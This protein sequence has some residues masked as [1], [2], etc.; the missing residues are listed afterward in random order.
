[1][2]KD[3]KTLDQKS[4]S[5]FFNERFPA[6]DAQKPVP[7]A[8]T[9]AVKAPASKVTV[10]P[11][12]TPAKVEQVARALDNAYGVSQPTKAF[13][14]TE[15]VVIGL[16]C[17][18]PKG[19]THQV[20]NGKKLFKI[21]ADEEDGLPFGPDIFVSMFLDT[22]YML[23]GCPENNLICFQ[24]ASD[25]LRFFYVPRGAQWDAFRP[26]KTQ[27][28]RLLGGFDRLTGATFFEKSLDD[29][30]EDAEV[31]QTPTSKKK[32]QEGLRPKVR[33]SY[34]L[35]KKTKFWLDAKGH[36]NQHSL[37]PNVVQIDTDHAEN[38]RNKKVV[39][40][41]FDLVRSCRNSVPRTKLA[42]FQRWRSHGLAVSNTN[43][44]VMPLL[45]AGGIANQL[46]LP[47]NARRTIE[48]IQR[49]QNEI[50]AVWPTC[51]NFVRGDT[52]VVRPELGPQMAV[53]KRLSRCVNRWTKDEDPFAPNGKGLIR[54]RTAKAL[55]AV[56]SSD[57][58]DRT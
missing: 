12:D 51:P 48:D 56:S 14:A 37:F 29:K 25:V 22:A 47:N 38:L 43:E 40:V 52:F 57:E 42:L 39:P 45:G 4:F 33:D 18:Q 58:D 23:L 34:R 6:L 24:S 46:T 2:A 53:D 11:Q 26:N 5:Q 20:I 44:I 19:T 15:F 10:V 16:P 1:M 21:V 50:R 3:L 54:L 41:D 30:S 31:L 13:L 8:Q 7:D 27:V 49:W 17:E 35:I 36:P 28:N 32:A 9:E 55:R